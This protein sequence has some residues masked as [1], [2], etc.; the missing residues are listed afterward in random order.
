MFS[1]RGL[2]HESVVEYKFKVPPPLLTVS[3]APPKRQK[4]KLCSHANPPPS[5]NDNSNNN[6]TNKSDTDKRQPS[7]FFRHLPSKPVLDNG[8]QLSN[9]KGV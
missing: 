5:N 4:E 3:Y 8:T 9:Q 6:N 2:Q 1:Y 7:K